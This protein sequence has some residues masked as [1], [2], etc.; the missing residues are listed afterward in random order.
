LSC[1]LDDTTE[2]RVLRPRSNRMADVMTVQ[3]I[4]YRCQLGMHASCCMQFER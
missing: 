1:H 4:H 3:H 2:R